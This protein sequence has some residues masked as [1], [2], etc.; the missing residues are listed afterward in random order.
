M[1][2]LEAFWGGFWDQSGVHFEMIFATK[3]DRN[4]W[5][6]W[7]AW[8][9]RE[10]AMSHQSTTSRVPH[11]ITSGHG[12]VL[13][14]ENRKKTKESRTHHPKQN[15]SNV[16]SASLL[17]QVYRLMVFQ[18]QCFLSP[19]FYEDF[20]SIWGTLW[21]TILVKNQEKCVAKTG[22]RRAWK[23]GPKK[24]WFLSGWNLEK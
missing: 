19:C 6:P 15:S 17:Y 24:V 1:N 4:C 21:G 22:L 20:G 14:S 3:L 12:G 11:D 16:L 5:V 10:S 2:D 18:N 8:A 23:R 7:P 13:Q 9:P